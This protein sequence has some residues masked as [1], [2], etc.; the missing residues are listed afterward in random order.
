MVF[1]GPVM[2]MFG[3]IFGATFQEFEASPTS[4]TSIFA[5]YLLTWNIITLFVGPPVQVKSERFVGICGTT[6]SITGL[7][8]CAFSTSTL[9]MMLAYGLAD[10]PGMGLSK[11]NGIFIL[12]KFFK[13]KIGLAFGLFA[14][15]LGVG[16]LALPQ[17]VKFLLQTFQE[18]KLFLYMLLCAALGILEQFLCG[19]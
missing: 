2:P 11:A 5:L 16:A 17:R 7:V 19:M 12:S 8:L 3:L 4:P 14:T 10:G 1:V 9:G 15:G 18:S 6:L 13:K